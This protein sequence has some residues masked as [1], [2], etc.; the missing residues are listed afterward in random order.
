MIL[1]LREL[2]ARSLMFTPSIEI[3]PSESSSIRERARLIELLPA[4]VLPTMPIFSPAP[5]VKLKPLRTVSV[6]S[7]YLAVTLSNFISPLSGQ[8]PI[9]DSGMI[10][11]DSNSS[12]G[13]LFEALWLDQELTHEYYGIS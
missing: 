5:T 12:C 13:I 1:D 8:L 6:F 11:S 7:L 2:K 3:L 9:L 10:A 4:P